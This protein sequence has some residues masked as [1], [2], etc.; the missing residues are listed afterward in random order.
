MSLPISFLVSDGILGFIVKYRM[1]KSRARFY[2][3][4]ALFAVGLL[5]GSFNVW[6]QEKSFLWKASSDKGVVYLLGSIHL[7]KSQDAI[8]KPIIDETFKKAKRLAFEV[9]LTDENPEKMRKL[10]LQK[11]VNLD[12]KNLQQKVSKETFQ[13]AT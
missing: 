8:L 5:A 13:W 9:D 1:G 6:A 2:A 10:I 7:L 4:H 3:L 11:G 12:G